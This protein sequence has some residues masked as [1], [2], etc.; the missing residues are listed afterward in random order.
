[1][2]ARMVSVGPVIALALYFPAII[3]AASREDFV[4]AT[5]LSG[6]AF[7]LAWSWKNR[8]SWRSR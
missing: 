7:L 8:G 3:R 2:K 5:L 1:M 4:G 6:A